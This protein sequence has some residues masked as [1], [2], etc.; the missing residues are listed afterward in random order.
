MTTSTNILI[1]KIKLL[2]HVLEKIVTNIANI[3][4]IPLAS[5]WGKDHSQ[6]VPRYFKISC[7]ILGSI[8]KKFARVYRKHMYF[9]KY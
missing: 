4:E 2:H 1:N 9:K 7:T 6:F 5:K 8:S 3:K